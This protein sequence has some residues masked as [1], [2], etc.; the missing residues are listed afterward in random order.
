MSVVACNHLILSL[1][2]AAGRPN[3]TEPSSY[4]L[5]NRPT[6]DII[7]VQ[8][9]SDVTD[10]Y[11]YQSQTILPAEADWN[12]KQSGLEQNPGSWHEVQSPGD[13]TARVS[14]EKD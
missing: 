13:P 12:H 5:S 9:A 3:S 7:F 8:Q 10:S 2:E 6:T 14:L 4:S 1:R 11:D